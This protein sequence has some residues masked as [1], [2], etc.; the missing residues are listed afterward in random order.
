MTNHQLWIRNGLVK[1][2]RTDRTYLLLS[3][4]THIT[5]EDKNEP[6]ASIGEIDHVLKQVSAF[7][8]RFAI[9]QHF[10]KVGCWRTEAI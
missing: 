9:Q 4:P 2:L 3:S 6:L 10:T 5:Y 1:L 7:H 8:K